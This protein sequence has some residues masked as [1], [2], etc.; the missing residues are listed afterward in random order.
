[1]PDYTTR[2]VDYD[3]AIKELETRATVNVYV[4]MAV[5]GVGEA[6]VRRAVKEGRLS[7]VKLGSRNFRIPSAAVKELL[8]TG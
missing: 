3:Q 6:T 5:L 2:Q 4:V 7:A 8:K 1:M